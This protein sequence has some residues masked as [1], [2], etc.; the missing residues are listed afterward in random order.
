MIE[1][2]YTFCLIA[3]IKSEVLTIT[4]CLGLGHEK[5]CPLYVFLYSYGVVLYE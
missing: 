1:M 4:H 3:I 5:W 2:I